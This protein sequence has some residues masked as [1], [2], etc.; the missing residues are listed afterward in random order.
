MTRKMDCAI[1]FL[2]YLGIAL[3]AIAS[4]ARSVSVDRA[5]V[6]SSITDLLTA[7]AEWTIAAGTAA[8]AHVP[9][10]VSLLDAR[11]VNVTA[12]ASW[13]GVPSSISLECD[14]SLKF[15]KRLRE[16]TCNIA[17]GQDTT[18]EFSFSYE[19]RGDSTDDE[20]KAAL[21]DN[22]DKSKGQCGE[23]RLVFVSSYELR[24][25]FALAES[26]DEESLTLRSLPLGTSSSPAPRASSFADRWGFPA[27]VYVGCMALLWVW[28]LV[29]SKIV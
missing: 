19:V 7:S 9:A 14:E 21:I 23:V 25:E 4:P 17:I 2:F 8:S 10:V 11:S 29:N 22:L 16:G 5:L 1:N 18:A 13:L 20:N 12:E 28:A 24:L 3:C 27:A 6:P 26:G 15:K